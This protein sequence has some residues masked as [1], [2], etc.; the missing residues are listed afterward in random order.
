MKRPLQTAAPSLSLAPFGYRFRDPALLEAALTHPSSTDPAQADI[1]LRYQR[2]EFLGD[3]VWNLHV[4]DALVSLL[5]DASE[6][7]LTQRRTQLVSAIALAEMAQR[8][9][10]APLLVLSKGE[11]STGGRQ[12][13]R[14]LATT[15]EAVIGA[16]YLDGGSEAI[17]ELARTV[18]VHALTKEQLTPDPKTALQQRVQSLLH[19]TPR[20]RLIR[21]SGT[22]HASTFEVEVVVGQLPVAS[23]KGRNRQ[24]AER[25]A[26]REALRSWPNP[27]A[28]IS[29]SKD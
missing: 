19:S 24:E 4:S 9:G 12:K 25:A 27:S 18:C 21:R 10:L 1:R 8:Y 28:T 23:G 11:E 7:E 2:L 29:G 15:F 17:H 26:A 3:A 16:I 13:T 20:Y 14:I 22:P 5:P 6:G